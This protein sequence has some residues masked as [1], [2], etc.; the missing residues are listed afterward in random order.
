MN[1]MKYNLSGIF[2]IVVFISISSCQKDP[3]Q[4]GSASII[5]YVHATVINSVNY[6]DTI[7]TQNGFNEEVFIVYGDDITF[8][9]RIKS[10]D[11]GKFEFKYLRKGNY[12]L[13]VYSETYDSLG[14]GGYTIDEVVNKSVEITSKKQTLNAGTFEI[15]KYK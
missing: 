2:I 15:R 8:G 13:Y 10:G 9:D 6:F 5:G 3:G 11:D 7:T 4:G 1:K 12:R 14:I